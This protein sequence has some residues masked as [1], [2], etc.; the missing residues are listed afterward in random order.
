MFYPFLLYSTVTQSYLDI[1]SFSHLI[2][3]HGLFP[4][5][6]IEFPVLYR[7]ISW[8]IHS[9][10]HGMHLRTPNFAKKKS[11]TKLVCLVLYIG[12]ISRRALCSWI[13]VGFFSSCS[14]SC[15]GVRM[16]PASRRQGAGGNHPPILDHLQVVLT[17]AMGSINHTACRK[18]RGQ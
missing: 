6:W 13:N 18:E 11:N 8:L 9:Q 2:F 7:R 5:E 17:L 15:V 4:R 3:H 14:L 1:H 16:S 10:C 12:P